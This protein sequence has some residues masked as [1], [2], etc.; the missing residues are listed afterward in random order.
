MRFERG[1][2]VAAFFIWM[3]SLFG[4]VSAPAAW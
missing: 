2:S 4:P 3:W 1:G